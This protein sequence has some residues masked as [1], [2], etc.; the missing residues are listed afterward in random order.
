MQAIKINYHRIKQI[1]PY[2]FFFFLIINLIPVFL[3]KFLPTLDGPSHLHNSNLINNIL[4]SDSDFIKSFYNLNTELIPNWSG[5]FILS[6]FNLFLPAWIAEKIL[7]LTYLI[8]LPLSFRWFIKSIS[9]DNYYLSYFIFPF[10]YSFTFFLGFYNFSLALVLLFLILTYWTKIQNNLKSIHFLILFLLFTVL[11]FSHVFVFLITTLAIAVIIIKQLTLDIEIN[12]LYKTFQ[13]FLK[14]VLFAVLT[15]AIGIALSLNFLLTR[16]A[17]GYSYIPKIE[18]LHWLKNIR[19]TIVFHFGHE[20]VYT[21]ILF[22][23]IAALTTIALFNKVKE[24]IKS[25]P[26]FT[27]FIKNS[28]VQNDLWFIF[29]FILLLLYF[30]MPDSNGYSG[31]FTVRLGL[32]LYMF[33]LIWIAT[34]NYSKWIIISS[35]TLIF[36]ANTGL[37]YY[38]LKQVRKLNKQAVEI[39]NQSKFIDNNTV[40]LPM[41]FSSNWMHGHFSNYLGIDKQVVILENYECSTGYFP[42]KWNDDSFPNTTIGTMLKSDFCTDWKTNKSSLKQYQVNYIFIIGNSKELED[43]CAQKSIEMIECNYDMV[44]QTQNTILYKL[45]NNQNNVN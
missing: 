41:N 33:Y 43:I 10:C 37:N 15:S 7:I 3:F 24:I 31:Y 13:L 12:S 26:S 4:F 42:V 34:R 14:K 38:Y 44:S 28:I 36:I 11:Y 1:E 23:L 5:H 29:S 2:F 45:K 39:N 19:P 20:G 30:F 22:Y 18:L 6:L 21:S 27:V 16:E 8:I 35:V 25:R 32:L 40:V 9:S 17:F